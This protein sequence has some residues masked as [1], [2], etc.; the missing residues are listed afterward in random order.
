MLGGMLSFYFG[1]TQL[2]RFKNQIK[3]N[4]LEENL[5]FLKIKHEI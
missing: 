4:E 2:A 5:V 3:R 1:S